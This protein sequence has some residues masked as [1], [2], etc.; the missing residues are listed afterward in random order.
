MCLILSS[1]M[2]LHPFLRKHCITS[3]SGTYPLGSTVSPS[4]VAPCLS[5]QDRVFEV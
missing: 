4:C 5:I 3:S 1:S 2:F